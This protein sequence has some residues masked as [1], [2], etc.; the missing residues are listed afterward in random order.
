MFLIFRTPHAKAKVSFV[1]LSIH[2]CFLHGLSFSVCSDHIIVCGSV[3]HQR[4]TSEYMAR[5][6]LAVLCQLPS[7]RTLLEGGR[8]GS[9]HPSL[10]LKRTSLGHSL[11]SEAFKFY[12]NCRGIRGAH[13]SLSLSSGLCACVH[14][15]SL[16]PG[17]DAEYVPHS[18]LFPSTEVPALELG[19]FH[20]LSGKLL[21]SRVCFLRENQASTLVSP[22]IL[23]AS[24]SPCS[25]SR[26]SDLLSEVCLPPFR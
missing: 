1:W 22:S 19:F 17:L 23:A 7:L 9:S 16:P 13:A 20:S 26:C 8:A 21:N 18:C 3:M 12:F 15:P 6:Q 25:P 2:K 4:F 5:P 24:S 14:S 11:V 10:F